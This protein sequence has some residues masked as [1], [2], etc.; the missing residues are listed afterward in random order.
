M[1]IAHAASGDVIHAIALGN[2]LRET[3]SH[4]LLKGSNLELIRLIMPAGK[5]MKDHRVSGEVTIHCLEGVLELS[6]PDKTQTLQAGDLVYLAGNEPH[7]LKAVMDAS[8]LLT[9]S[10]TRQ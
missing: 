7:G 5:V 2:E 10:L 4:A 1:A 3:P 9:I 8:V 6:T